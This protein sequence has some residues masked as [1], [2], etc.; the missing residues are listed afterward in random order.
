MLESLITSEESTF[1]ERCWV[2]NAPDR[3]LH[4]TA[5]QA[6]L[7][8]SPC[9]CPFFHLLS[10][11][12]HLLYPQKDLW[13]GSQ[14]SKTCNRQGFGEGFGFLFLSLFLFPYCIFLHP[15]THPLQLSWTAAKLHPNWTGGMGKGYMWS[16]Q[17]RRIKTALGIRVYSG[18]PK[19]FS[20]YM[21]KIRIFETHCLFPVH[22]VGS[23]SWCLQRGKGRGHTPSGLSSLHTGLSSLNTIIFLSSLHFLHVYRLPPK[24]LKVLLTFSISYFSRLSGSEI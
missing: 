12:Q 4:G 21:R 17:Y 10:L 19:K 24:H 22:G 18:D 1:R 3:W 5:N 14:E 15:F 2:W 23:D 13:V 8:L 11:W 7:P 6:A 16:A 20:L 9:F